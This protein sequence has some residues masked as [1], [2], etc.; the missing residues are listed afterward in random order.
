[1]PSFKGAECTLFPVDEV[2]LQSES[3]PDLTGEQMLIQLESSNEIMTRF[4]KTWKALQ[5]ILNDNDF[6]LLNDSRLLDLDAFRNRLQDILQ[7]GEIF[8]IVQTIFLSY[9]LY[10]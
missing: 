5:Q 2:M 8:A 9:S 3:P 10:L 4:M 6:K 1:M 7:K